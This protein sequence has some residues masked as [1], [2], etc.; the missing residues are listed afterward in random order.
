[1]PTG[2]SCRT[3]LQ[4]AKLTCRNLLLPA[5]SKK[6]PQYPKMVHRGRFRE[7]ACVHMYINYLQYHHKYH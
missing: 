6:I 2:P 1:M 7:L 3:L 5:G 4:V